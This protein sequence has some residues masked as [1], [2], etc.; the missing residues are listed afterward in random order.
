MN[1][2]NTERKQNGMDPKIK[3]AAI[4][5]VVLLVAV[6]ASLL[7]GEQP[8]EPDSVSEKSATVWYDGKELSG[9]GDSVDKMVSDALEDYNLIFNSNG[10]IRSIDGVTGTEDTSWVIFKWASPKG[11]AVAE[12]GTEPV[13]GV[14]LAVELSEFKENESGTKSYV[15]P[16]IEVKYQVH[17]YLKF[18][19]HYSENHWM[20][21]VASE[22]DRKNGF[23]ISGW[24]SNNNEALFDAI[25]TNFFSDTDMKKIEHPDR[26]EYSIDGETGIFTHGIK[27]DMYGWFLWFFGWEDTKIDS[28]GEYGTYT[29]WNQYLYDPYAKTDDDPD[30]WGFN[31]WAF[32]LYDITEY[33]Y[34][35]LVLRTTTHEGE[36]VEL[37]TPSEYIR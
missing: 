21:S 33:K 15:L 19:E 11:W 24:G 36:P 17:Y 10:T 13:D 9:V 14:T 31:Q 23:W 12:R 4:V 3:I 6:T 25:Y 2:D 37:P 26:V 18:E 32:G 34:F 5:V 7:V 1:K 8:D 29:F 20:E 22:E 16:D 27:P 28:E 30:A 35:G